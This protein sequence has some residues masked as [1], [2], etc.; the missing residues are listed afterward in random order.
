MHRA[1]VAFA[2]G[3]MVAASVLL[4]GVALA[5]APLA[6]NDQA[7]TNEDTQ[8]TI[9]LLAND[10]DPDGDALAIASIAQPANGSV[11]LTPYLGAVSYRPNRN[12][13]GT[14]RFSYQVSDGTGETAS[15][16]VV[17]FV[18]A[19]NDAPVPYK[20]TA[21]VAEDGSVDILFAA[22]D[23]DSERC[24]LVFIA[25][26]ITQHGRLSPFVDAGCTPNADFAEATYTPLPGYNGL[27]SISFFVSD[28]ELQ[29]G[30]ARIDITVTPIDDPPVAFPVT[31]TTAYQTPVTITL[32]GSDWE[33][34]ELTFAVVSDPTAGTLL[35]GGEPPCSGGA[36]SGPNTDSVRVI[37]TPRNDFSGVDR[38][39]YTVT[40]DRTTS[41]PALVEVTVAP[42]SSMHVG[43][44]DA[45]ARR[46]PGS[47]SATAT[48]E[49]EDGA[50][51]GVGGAVVSGWW[52]DGPGTTCTTDSSGRCSIASP[53]Y[54][55]RLPAATFNVSTVS[56]AG[57]VYDDTANHDPDGDS[58]GSSISVTRP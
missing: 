31:V 33:T 23:P 30:P 6:G 38:F 26:S 20:G 48:I 11:E 5:A 58:S 17:V 57:Y 56:R 16:E 50:G 36:P 2:T 14:D 7:A 8:V 12:F 39:T 47:W 51:V 45:T 19:V 25:E 3:L 13:N 9:D 40:A 43:D 18:A 24:D 37:Y 42:P 32:T 49:I 28:G 52:T 55:R 41:E 44:L 4:P 27:D 29:G 46:A 54:S 35:N 1:T 15:A 10:T 21:T 53:P 34:C 22:S